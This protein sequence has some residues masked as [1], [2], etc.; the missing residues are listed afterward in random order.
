MWGLGFWD[1][2]FRVQGLGLQHNAE[3]AFF[4]AGR[5]SRRDYVEARAEV[6]TCVWHGTPTRKQYT[7]ADATEVLQGGMRPK[8]NLSTEQRKPSEADVFLKVFPHGRSAEIMW[9]AR[10]CFF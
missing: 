1:S 6:A 9:R 4:P 8:L 2:G 10:T 5:N 3:V 7:L